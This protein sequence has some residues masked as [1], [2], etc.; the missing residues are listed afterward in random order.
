MMTTTMKPPKKLKKERP[1]SKVPEGMEWL[2]SV[3][4]R[5]AERSRRELWDECRQ[6]WFQ[7]T[8]K[9]PK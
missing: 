1:D 4:D 3:A 5:D 7:D 6:R 2:A 9:T 8:P